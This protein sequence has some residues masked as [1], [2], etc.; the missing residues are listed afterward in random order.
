M[1]VLYHRGPMSAVVITAW[2]VQMSGRSTWKQNQLSPL[3]P[4]FQYFSAGSN[5]FPLVQR[6]VNFKCFIIQANIK[7]GP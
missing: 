2:D 4:H 1:A 7:V 6:I 5:N 3:N